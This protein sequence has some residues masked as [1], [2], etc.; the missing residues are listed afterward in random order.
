MGPAHDIAGTNLRSPPAQNVAANMPGR[1]NVHR[2]PEFSMRRSIC[3]G[4]I[5]LLEERVRCFVRDGKENDAP[6]MLRDAL[7]RGSNSGRRGGPQEEYR[8]DVLQARIKRFGKSGIS[9]HQRDLWRQTAGV[10]FACQ[11][12]DLRAF[13]GQ[14]RKHMAANVAA[15]S[16]DEDTIPA[17][18]PCLSAHLRTSWRWLLG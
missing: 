5:G 17:R 7:H 14:L 2:S 13:C 8:V 10:R 12:A 6:S 4:R 11:R 16:D 9:A 18:S 1:R 3:L 15:A